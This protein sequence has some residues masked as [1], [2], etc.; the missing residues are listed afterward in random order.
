MAQTFQQLSATSLNSS[1]NQQIPSLAKQSFPRNK[2]EARD[3][4]RREA[5]NIEQPAALFDCLALGATQFSLS[6]QQ[7]VR[8]F[9]TKCNA[10]LEALLSAIKEKYHDEIKSLASEEAYADLIV[11]IGEEFRKPLH[12]CVVASRAFKLF[13]ALR[14]FELVEVPVEDDI[15]VSEF[16]GKELAE[17]QAKLDTK[18]EGA[19]S[20]TIVTP[21]LEEERAEETTSTLYCGLPSDLISPELFLNFIRRVYLDQDVSEE[22][23]KLN[24]RLIDWIKLHKPDRIR[25]TTNKYSPDHQESFRTVRPLF[26]ELSIV[27]GEQKMT[28]ELS[29]RNSEVAE[30]PTGD[31]PE[32]TSQAISVKDESLTGSLLTRTETFELISRNNHDGSSPSTTPSKNAFAESNAVDTSND[33]NTPIPFT[34]TTR[35]GLK[36]KTFT[37]PTGMLHGPTRNSTGSTPSKQSIHNTTKTKAR[38]EST[39]AA[40][41]PKSV[42]TV[43]QSAPTAA[44]RSSIAAKQSATTPDSNKA[45]SVAKTKI[46]SP[47]NNNVKTKLTSIVRA[48][49]ISLERSQ[50]PATSVIKG[51]RNF[52][53]ANKRYVAQLEKKNTCEQGPDDPDSEAASIPAEPFTSDN[54]V[55][56]M[57]KFTLIS[58]S[59]LAEALSTMFID[60]QLSDTIILSSNE[61][62]I[63]AHKCILAARSAYLAEI[64]T[65]QSNLSML[66]MDSTSPPPSFPTHSVSQPK[67]KIDLTEYSYPAVYFSI[68][69]I[70]NGIVKV[71][72]D[73]D[74][75]ELTKLAHLL[76]VTTLRQVCMNNLRM[77]YC[78][79]FHKPCNVCCLGVLKALPLAWRY[80]Y[81]ELYSKCLQWIGSHFASIFCLKEF[82]ELKPHDLVEE[83]YLATLSQLTPDNII[84]K[85]IECQ[86]L[87]KNLPRVKWTESIICLVGR[88]LED[89]CHYVADNYEKILQTD[90]F[91]NLGKN[92]WECEILE[93][94]LLAA[95]NHLKPDSGCR[96]LIQLHKIECSLENYNEDSRNAS[97]SFANLIFKMRKYCER[98]LLKEATAVVHCSSWRHMNPSLQKRIKDQ[99]IISTDFD[100]P[101]KQIAP[102]PKL[103]SSSRSTFQQQS[104]GTNNNNTDGARSPSNRSTPDS[105]LKSPSTTYLKS[106]AAATRHV[107]VLK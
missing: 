89:F 4:G 22:E 25:P 65:K 53:E 67:L 36:P 37:T 1:E 79:F 74:L 29:S 99:A 82:S 100:E 80:D 8:G 56:Q 75:D 92:G 35:T 28:Q 26:E 6:R 46:A 98:Y 83:C 14:A 32:E 50:S 44:K 19:K 103:S 40:G 90:T 55:A 78:H 15:I 27:G 31:D 5:T 7:T 76:H 86:K 24:Q 9:I 95:M 57:D 51:A 11:Q 54:L 101:N 94:N 61:K 66:S 38:E 39:K 43:N 34:P 62:Q 59:K 96:T 49:P 104:I 47:E 23:N 10:E 16:Q 52:I 81:T 13:N 97:D 20:E 71:P 33:S 70:Y 85:T 2:L 87:L 30:S 107:K 106:K 63:Q 73:V 41:I 77:I 42:I 102:K 105:K 17:A 72:D 93:E 68:M 91:L 48:Q 64:I 58:Y 12:K 84:P 60:G 18:E 69:H 3:Q 45:N 88:Q 21:D